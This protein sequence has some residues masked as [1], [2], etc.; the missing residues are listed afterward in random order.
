MLMMATANLVG[1][2][3]GTEGVSYLLSQLVN[4]WQGRRASLVRRC[5]LSVNAGIRFLT[6][7]CVCIF[8]AAQVM[9]EYR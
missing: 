7:A 2:V 1:F 9:F 8:V 5:K 6:V 3:I 4:D